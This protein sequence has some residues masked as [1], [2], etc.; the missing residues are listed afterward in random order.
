MSNVNLRK[1]IPIIGAILSGKSFFLD[2]LLGLDI[3]DSQSSIT[4]KFVC[5]IQ[6]H[7]DLKEP[8]FYQINLVQSHLDENNMM[9]YNGSMKGDITYGHDNI[10]EKIKEINRMQKNIPSEQIKY[11]ELFYVLE[12]GIKNIENEKLLN[13][14]DFYDIPG[15]DEYIVD[16]DKEKEKAKTDENKLKK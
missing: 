14:Y 8:K 12:I 9:V 4:T 2:S 13:D 3:L 11:E 7:K 1:A 10:K 16:K 5:I 15:L 6:N